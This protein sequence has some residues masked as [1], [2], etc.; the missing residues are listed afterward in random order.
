MKLLPLGKNG[1]AGQELQRSLAPLG[2]LVA[3]DRQKVDG[4]FADLPGLPCLSK[5]LE[6]LSVVADQIGVPAGADAVTDVI[7]LAIQQI[8]ARK[9]LPGIHYVLAKQA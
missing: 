7:A 3:Q 2:E 6:T 4:L 1:Q 8:Q 5:E 9:E